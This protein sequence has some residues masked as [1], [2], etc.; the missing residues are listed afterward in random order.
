MYQL[1]SISAFMSPV[2][3]EMEVKNGMATVTGP[4]LSIVFAVLDG[5]C[6]RLC[7]YR[8]PLEKPVLV[9][10]IHWIH[11]RQVYVWLLTLYSLPE[12]SLLIYLK[13]LWTSLSSFE[14]EHSEIRTSMHRLTLQLW[15]ELKPRLFHFQAVSKPNHWGIAQPRTAYNLIANHCWQ[16]AGLVGQR[17]DVRPV[18]K[19]W[20]SNTQR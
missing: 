8:D 11:W 10:F 2:V 15:S 12:L 20:V 4:T 3:D 6:W 1:C 16:L 13:W 5:S 9:S 17:H 19:K 18:N 14:T 7:M